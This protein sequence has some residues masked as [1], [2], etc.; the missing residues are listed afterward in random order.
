VVKT[1]RFSIVVPDSWQKRDAD[2]GSLLSPPGDAPASVQ[3]FYEADPGMSKEVLATQTAGFL[4]SRDPGAK[5]GSPEFHSV[6]GDPG[7]ELHAVGP[8]GTQ[9][10]IGVLADP[11]RYLVIESADPTTPKSMREEADKALESF[12]P[13]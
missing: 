13:R 4:R 5:V 2:G 6:A 12:E 3:V 11:Y 1:A 10:A 8:A 7:F 9:V